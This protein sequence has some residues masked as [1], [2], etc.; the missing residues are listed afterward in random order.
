VVTLEGRG[1]WTHGGS[2]AT[3]HGAR[4][5][6]LA[7]LDDEH[8]RWQD[9]RKRL[10]DL[11]KEMKRRAALNDANASRA[12][13]SETRLRH[14]DEAGPPPER[15]AEQSISMRLGGGRTGKRALA[16][17]DFALGRSHEGV[18]DGGALRRAGRCRRHE[19]HRQEPLPA[20]ARW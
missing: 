4:Q 17:E 16:L 18:H 20:A 13:A 9:E 3:Y 12:R 5:E 11:M 7:R 10:H 6:R 1:A 14:F 15:A 8:R 19:W 2:F